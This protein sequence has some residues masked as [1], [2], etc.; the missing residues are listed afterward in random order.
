MIETIVYL[1]IIFGLSEI[2]LYFWIKILSKK[3]QWLITK[4][5]ENPKLDEN[6]LKKFIDIG[7][8][9]ELGWIRKPNTSNFEFG[10]EGKTKWSINNVGARYNPN[11]ENMKSD[12][13]CFGD[14]FTFC[15]QVNDNETWEYYLSKLENTNVKNFGVGNYGIDQSLLRLKRQFTKDSTEKV[16]LAVVPDTISRIMSYWKHYYEYGNT[17]AFKPK[18]TLQNNE[19]IILKNLIDSEKKL[20]NYEKYLNII[21]K[22]DYFYKNKFRKEIIKFPYSIYILKNFRRNI[23]LIYWLTKIEIYKKL[24]KSISKIEWY[25]MKIIMDINLKWRIKLYQDKSAQNLLK[26]IIEEYVKIGIEK[27][28]LPIFFFI[29]QK[30]D[31]IFI[32][33]NFNFYCNFIQEIKKIN[34]INIIDVTEKFLEKQNFDELYSDE[35]QYGG[36]LSRKGNKF[37]ATII[38]EKLKKI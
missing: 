12:I 21:K 29:P 18:F 20:F 37:L 10:A 36:H 33:N 31:L 7:Y 17:F 6:G 14:S 35:N 1:L 38:H 24:N 27:N 22:E 25:P 8:D 19:L 28:F 11:F 15:R 13:V 3:F 16:I 23:S 9:F 34:G 32:K 26:K 2:I 4:K 30:D 5:D